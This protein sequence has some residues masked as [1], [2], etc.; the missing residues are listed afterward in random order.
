MIRRKAKKIILK[1]N[2]QARMKAAA[3][4]NRE[5]FPSFQNSV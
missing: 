4:S 5:L 2:F 1:P 3:L